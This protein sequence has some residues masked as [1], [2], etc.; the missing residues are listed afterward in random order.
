MRRF[1]GPLILA[2]VAIALPFWGAQFTYVAKDGMLHEP[3]FFTV[4]LGEAMLLGAVIWGGVV[5]WRKW[6]GR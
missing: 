2:V 3:Y 4:P 6:R 5:A 1:V